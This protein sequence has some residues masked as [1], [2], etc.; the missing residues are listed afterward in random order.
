VAWQGF[1]RYRDMG[2]TRSLAKA[3]AAL[4]RSKRL[5]ERWCSRWAWVARCAAWDAEQDRLAREAYTRARLEKSQQTIADLELFQGLARRRFVEWAKK[6]QEMPEAINEMGL[7]EARLI[8]GDAEKLKR[9]LMGEP[10]AI[11]ETRHAGPGGEPLV[12]TVEQ[13]VEARKRI[14]NLRQSRQ[15]RKGQQT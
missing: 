15:N 13:I 8:Y 9:V 6:I 5:L 14:E 3:A 7:D 10:A 1:Q 11:A 4:N 2:P 12:I